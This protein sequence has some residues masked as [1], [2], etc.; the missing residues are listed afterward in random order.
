MSNL[1]Q[2][3]PYADR[4]DEAFLAEMIALTTHHTQW[5]EP[6]RQIA[7][8][9]HWNPK[10]AITTSDIPFVHVGLFKRMTL[11]SNAP[12]SK[13]L[14]TVVS[15]STSGVSSRVQLD[16]LSS[17]LQSMSSKSILGDFVGTS[18]RPLLVLDSV[19]SLRR[20]DDFSA[21]IM[22][23]MSL[24]PFATEVFF[25]LK[26]SADPTSLQIAQ[27][28]CAL[29]SGTDLLVYGF[30]W[31]LWLS[32]VKASFPIEIS[33]E[34][35]HRNITFV[36]SGG[37][38]KLEDIRVDHQTFDSALLSAS[39][40][41]SAV[42]DYY[43]LVE[44]MGIVF[45]LCSH[46]SRHVPRWADVI[47]RDSWTLQALTSGD[48][49]LQLMNSLSFSSPCHSV[50]TEDMGRLLPGECPCGRKGKRF[51]LLGRVPKAEVRGCAN[52]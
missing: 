43:G 10:S 36:H 26:D 18:K 2:S 9:A 1:L 15:S 48:G 47:V 12:D 27:L 5:C 44:Q 20:R 17:G 37:W 24:K 34:L 22:A 51:E 35:A 3:E 4:D 30:S 29:K 50:L 40:P 46:G 45:P 31:I 21:R 19:Q 49:Q 25:L 14:R 33:Q 41:G 32:W 28:E 6:F 16:E 8:A 39:G 42:V 13:V 38:K 23:A 11:A 52:V 7:S